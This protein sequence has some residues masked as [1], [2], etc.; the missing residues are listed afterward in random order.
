M[1]R[2]LSKAD[3][4]KEAFEAETRN[5]LR[6]LTVQQLR[7]AVREATKDVNIRARTRESEQSEI[8]LNKLK[9]A[10]LEVEDRGDLTRAKKQIGRSRVSANVNYKSKEELIS[11]YQALRKYQK[12]DTES[13][14]AIKEYEQGFEEAYEKF[15]NSDAGS[16]YSKDISLSEFKEIIN[17]LDTFEGAISKKEFKYEVFEAV[18]TYKKVKEAGELKPTAS[19][20]KV[21]PDE[22]VDILL[23][24]I[25][26]AS[27]EDAAINNMYKNL[28]IV[29]SGRK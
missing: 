22:V 28:G 7:T 25:S 10:G 4:V 12:A 29:R 3:I 27:T 18:K 5:D 14:T 23:S 19:G 8:A 13:E 20:K 21:E 1:A 6:K 11:Q 26:S 9:I 24:S 15:K 17:K 2:N 16:N